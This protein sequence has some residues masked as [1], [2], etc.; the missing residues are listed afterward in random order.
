[1]G[2]KLYGQSA[3]KIYK[4]LVDFKAGRKENIVKKG[5]L[6]NTTEEELRKFDDENG[7]FAS[8]TQE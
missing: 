1:M 6:I 8:Q 4:D 7:A 3:D 2:P 5:L